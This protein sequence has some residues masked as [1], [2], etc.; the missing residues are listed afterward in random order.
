MAND[1][2]ELAD[3]ESFPTIIP[4]GHDWGSYMAQRLYLWRPTRCAG[5]ILLNVA[6]QPPSNQPFNLSAALDFAEQR[7]GYPSLAYWEVFADPQGA[8]LLSARLETFFHLL[9]WDDPNAMRTVFCTRGALRP[10]LDDAPEK[11]SLKPYAKGKFKEEFLARFRRDGLVSPQCWYRVV[12]ENVASEAEKEIPKENLLIKVPCLYI[13]STGDTVC[14][15]DLM[16]PVKGL[17][18]DLET[19]VVD[20]N[21]WCPYEKPEEVRGFM[22]EW[23]KKKF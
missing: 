13:S 6:Y 1:L 14:R 17:V 12:T 10:L 15:T 4:T 20:A 16:E 9:H 23:L 11:Y 22:A 8:A 3:S 7:F 19:Y 18:P 2:Y 21:H 5:L